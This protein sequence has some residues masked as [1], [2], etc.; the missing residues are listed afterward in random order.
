MSKS[1]LEDALLTTM[2]QLKLPAPVRE[3]RF[4][5][6]RLF[7]ADFAYPEQ[8]LLIEVDG[9]IWKQGGG[10]HNRGSGFVK[11]CEKYAIAAIHGF[12]VIRVT[13]KHIEDY[14]A[15]MWI[16]QALEAA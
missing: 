8:K 11:D 2:K 12:R 1:L 4:A 15:A 9:G 16:A 7:R 10:R 14:R 6:P 13:D 5:P 3:F